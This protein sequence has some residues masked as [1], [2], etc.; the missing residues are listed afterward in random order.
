MSEGPSPIEMPSPEA[1]RRPFYRR[2]KIWVG[3]AI[4][5]AVVLAVVVVWFEPQKLFLD[6]RVDEAF[7]V[8]A[9]SGDGAAGSGGSKEP[10]GSSGSTGSTTSPSTDPGSTEEPGTETPPTSSAEPPT[11]AGPVTV[12]NGTFESID[13]DTSGKALVVDVGDGTRVLRLEDLATDNGPDVFV[14]LSAAPIS[15]GEEA[16]DDDFV[17]LGGL[18][19]NLGNQNYEVPDDVDLERYRT[20][21]IWCRR[22]SSGFGAADLT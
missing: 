8:S 4:A 14:Y 13:H 3:G 22:F 10:A 12:A 11:P 16:L 18:K 19:G 15:D 7:P 6:E 9:S 2:R 20:V 5:V 21:V 1:E 17:D